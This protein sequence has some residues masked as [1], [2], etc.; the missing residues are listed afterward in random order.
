MNPSPQLSY[1][2]LSPSDGEREKTGGFMGSMREIVRENPFRS[3]GVR[4]V[5]GAPGVCLQDSPRA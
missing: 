2:P 1:E 5:F 4:V 3:D